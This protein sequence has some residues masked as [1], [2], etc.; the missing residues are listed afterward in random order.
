MPAA[1]IRKARGHQLVL[2]LIF[3]VAQTCRR[4]CLTAESMAWL[5]VVGNERFTAERGRRTGRIW[6]VVL[7]P[8]RCASN[9][10]VLGLRISTRTVR[11]NPG[12]PPQGV[13]MSPGIVFSTRIMLSCWFCAV[14]VSKFASERD[15]CCPADLDDAPTTKS[16]L[17]AS[18]LLCPSM[19]TGAQ[20]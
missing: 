17:P 7:T 4:F 10:T 8:I 3:R 6:K 1:S 11:A 16:R 20:S 14:A 15:G 19:R 9:W 13:S 5:M 18:R 2:I 12:R